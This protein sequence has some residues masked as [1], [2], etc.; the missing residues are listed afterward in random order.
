MKAV[1]QQRDVETPTYFMCGRR[2]IP[3]LK[4]KAQAEAE[5]ILK[6]F[7][8]FFKTAG[9]LSIKVEP[10]EHETCYSIGGKLMWDDQVLL[11]E[12]DCGLIFLHLNEVMLNRMIQLGL[13][14]GPTKGGNQ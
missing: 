5:Q 3:V 6:E 10:I 9:T 4:A 13:L 14:S 2:D 12:S 11:S 8:M 7:A 1:I